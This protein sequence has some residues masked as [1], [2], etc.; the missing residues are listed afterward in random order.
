MIFLFLNLFK[1]LGRRRQ[2][3]IEIR[4]IVGTN[5]ALIPRNSVNISQGKI[6]ADKTALQTQM[7]FMEIIKEHRPGTLGTEMPTLLRIANDCYAQ[8]IEDARDIMRET[9][10]G[11]SDAPPSSNGQKE[12]GAD[13]SDQ[14]SISP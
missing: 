14:T 3:F 9:F 11:S 2:V 1:I 6:V 10:S 7:Q 5:L 8:G 12:S 4:I 13:T